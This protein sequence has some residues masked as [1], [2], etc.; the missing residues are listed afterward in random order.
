MLDDTANT[1]VVTPATIAPGVSQLMVLG[2]AGQDTIDASGS[3]VPVFLDG[4]ADTDTLIGSTFDDQIVLRGGDDQASDVGGN[5]EY[6]LTPNSV[7][8]ITD[9]SGDNTLVSG[10]PISA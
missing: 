9:G 3:P 4:G 1:Y 5:D 10:S 2:L 7:L 8:S 6:L